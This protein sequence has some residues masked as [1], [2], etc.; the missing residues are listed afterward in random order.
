[1]HMCKAERGV[2]YGTAR[3]GM[4]AQVYGCLSGCVGAGVFDTCRYT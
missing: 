2:R 4:S 3:G 1:M